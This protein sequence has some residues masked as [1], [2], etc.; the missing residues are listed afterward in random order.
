MELVCEGLGKRGSVSRPRSFRCSSFGLFFCRFADHQERHYHEPLTDYDTK[1]HLKKWLRICQIL[2]NAFEK[3]CRNAEGE[4]F[5]AKAAKLAIWGAELW[6]W[7]LK[8]SSGYFLAWHFW[9]LKVIQFEHVKWQGESVGILLV[10]GGTCK[11][12]RNLNDSLHGQ[13]LRARLA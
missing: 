9:A 7:L 1:M 8:R 3:V 6:L 4:A 11:L 10:A 5:F 2:S 13:H 12:H